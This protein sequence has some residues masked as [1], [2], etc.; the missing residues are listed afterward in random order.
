MGNL[1]LEQVNLTPQQVQS[2]VV[3]Q[4]RFV[5]NAM[6]ALVRCGGNFS[7][8]DYD[9][10]TNAMSA[11]DTLLSY[12]YEQYPMD[13]GAIDTGASERVWKILKDAGWAGPDAE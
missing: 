9:H 3:D 5:A 1:K 2:A 12:A 11:M 6:A 7:D 13:A 4:A 10:V 8:S